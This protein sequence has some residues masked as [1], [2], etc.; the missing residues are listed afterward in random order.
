VVVSDDKCSPVTYVSGDDGDK[1]LEVGETWKYTC[2]YF[3]KHADE[4]A[5]GNV[6]NTVT[7]AGKDKLDKLV[8]DDDKWSTHVMHAAILV[9]KTG[10]A[11]AQAGDLLPYDL[12]VTNPGDEGLAEAAITVNDPLCDGS[13]VLVSKSTGAGADA[14]PGSLDPGDSWAYRCSVQTQVGQTDVHNV[15]TACALDAAGVQVCDDDP[16]D[17]TLTQPAQLVLPERI[18]PGNARLFGPTGCAA[19]A[20]GARVRGAKIAKVVFTLDGRKVMT[21][22]KPN[23]GANYQYRVNPARLRVGVHRLVATVTFA[24]GSGTK[25]K[26]LRLSFQ[27][28]AHRLAIPKF[29]G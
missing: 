21:L 25:A 18:T 26:V 6:V 10:P 13:P 20:F 4:D 7:A 8:Q 12:V 11:T 28:C 24:R 19:K 22:A 17:T 5:S 27:R 15:G 16:A 9:D 14:T 29:T 3:V 2:D 23:S 1:L